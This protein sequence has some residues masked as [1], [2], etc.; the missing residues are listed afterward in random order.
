[1]ALDGTRYLAG[2]EHEPRI[3]FVDRVKVDTG[4][5]GTG[6]LGAVADFVGGLRTSEMER[7][8]LRWVGPQ[9]QNQVSEFSLVVQPSGASWRL[10]SEFTIGGADHGWSYRFQPYSLTDLTSPPIEHTAAAFRELLDATA[11]HPVESHRRAVAEAQSI[12][13]GQI[14]VPDDVGARDRSAG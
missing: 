1:M 12:L 4:D 7:L 8:V 5:S 6:S 10:H 2:D 9:P 13:E 11:A 14:P 3:S